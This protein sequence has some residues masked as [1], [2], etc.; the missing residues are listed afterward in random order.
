MLDG[1]LKAHGVLID[2]YSVDDLRREIGALERQG[3]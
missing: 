1:F 2:D 3:F